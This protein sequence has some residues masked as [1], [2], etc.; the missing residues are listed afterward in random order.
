MC[1]F[2]CFV[3]GHFVFGR[4][5]STPFNKLLVKLF[6]SNNIFLFH[7]FKVLKVINL[8]KKNIRLL[9]IIIQ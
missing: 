6:A 4:I 3:T 2:G 9:K 1:N 8:E 7:I 5:V